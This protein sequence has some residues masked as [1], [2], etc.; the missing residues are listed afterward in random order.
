[1]S[2]AVEARKSCASCNTTL[3][4]ILET[5]RVGCSTCYATFP[6]QLESL[7]EGIHVALA[8]RGKVPRVSDARARVRADLQSKRGLLKTALTTENYEEA[9]A[10]RDEIKALETGLSSAEGGRD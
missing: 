6:V 4:Q 5:G 9:A 1:V 10:L 3:R 8:H 7:L 2:D